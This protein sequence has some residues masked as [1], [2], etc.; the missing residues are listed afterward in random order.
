[1]SQLMTI[2]LNSNEV[3]HK[4]LDLKSR[5]LLFQLT[6]AIE[7]FYHL[8]A[9]ALPTDRVDSSVPNSNSF[10]WCFVVMCQV[11]GIYNFSMLL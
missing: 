10:S 5:N 6:T 11:V 2:L 3:N 1:M 8:C 4:Q 7:D 9:I